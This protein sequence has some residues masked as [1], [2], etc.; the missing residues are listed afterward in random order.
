MIP[1]LISFLSIRTTYLCMC[2]M[3]KLRVTNRSIQR[4][5]K[6]SKSNEPE[7]LR[8][9][10]YRSNYEKF[11]ETSYKTHPHKRGGVKGGES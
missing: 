2:D 6:T 1:H 11:S 8:E 10:R 7:N 4:A 5:V 3:G 9:L